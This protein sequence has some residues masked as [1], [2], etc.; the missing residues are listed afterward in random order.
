[1]VLFKSCHT[2]WLL[3]LSTEQRQLKH[4]SKVDHTKYLINLKVQNTIL[5]G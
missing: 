3:G 4:C 2:F 1:M 5:V